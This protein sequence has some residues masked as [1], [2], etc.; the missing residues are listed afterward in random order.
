MSEGRV[1]SLDAPA[2]ANGC[3]PVAETAIDDTLR[4]PESRERFV[5]GVDVFEQL[6]HELSQ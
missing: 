3:Y 2:L 4:S 6:L 1:L 5:S